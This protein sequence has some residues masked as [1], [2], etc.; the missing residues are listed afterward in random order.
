[1]SS[2]T[3]IVQ[4]QKRLLNLL[5]TCL[6]REP[7]LEDPKTVEIL[8]LCRK[9]STDGNAEFLLKLCVYLRQDVGFVTF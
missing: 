1:M 3:A 4:A 5:S 9:I 6:I 8:S 7:K 2:I